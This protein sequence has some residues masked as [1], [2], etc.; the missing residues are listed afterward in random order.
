[1]TKGSRASLQDKTRY[2]PAEVER[3]IF[4]EWIEGGYF[5]PVAKG[6]PGG[7]LLGRDP[8]AQ[9]DRRPAHGPRAERLD[10]GRAGADEPDARAQH[11]LD[12][13]H[14]PRRDRHPVGGREGA[15]RRGHLAARSWAARGSS[16]GSG[17]GRRST[18]RESSSSTSGS[19]PPVTTSAS[20]SPSTRAMSAPST[21]SSSSSMTSGYIYRDNYMVNWDP[22]SHSA[23]SDLEVE[24]R[25]VEDTLY[26]DRLPGRGLRAGADRRHGAPGDDARRHRG[27]GQ[28]RRRALRRAGRAAL[29]PAAGRP[30][31]ADH[32][33]P[34]RRPRVRHRGAED[35]P[36]P[37]SQRLRDR[38]P[39][40]AGGDR[41]DRSRR[42][43]DRGGRAASRG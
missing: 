17:P 15:A 2:D 39:A 5:H 23:I 3:R 24:N 4:A 32:R 40:R 28:S 43:D 26:F 6:T 37:R 21:G 34:A 33:R 9:R 19:A 1:M 12:P 18:A 20:A 8:A 38:P 11:A 10:P 35:H 14:R 42:A 16:S 41:R 22:G 36:R 7:E 30:P 29:R 31:P 25:E 27:R 13:R